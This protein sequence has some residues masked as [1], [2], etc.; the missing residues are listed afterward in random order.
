MTVKGSKSCYLGNGTL[1]IIY[2]T[3][4]FF[5]LVSSVRYKEILISENLSIHDSEDKIDQ[6]MIFYSLH[7]KLSRN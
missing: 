3:V 6:L 1:Q 4:F 5:S 2:S 7:E